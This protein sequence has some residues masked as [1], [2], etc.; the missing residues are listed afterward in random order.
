MSEP[1]DNEI[2]RMCVSVAVTCLRAVTLQS[3]FRHQDS[4]LIRVLSLVRLINV[5][6]HQIKLPHSFIARLKSVLLH[7]LFTYFLNIFSFHNASLNFIFNFFV[8]AFKVKYFSSYEIR[9]VSDN[10]IHHHHHEDY[11][12]SLCDYLSHSM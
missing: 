6:S 8:G 2:V 7:I 4:T 9:T 1:S 12:Q 5:T 11:Y 3:F 10:N